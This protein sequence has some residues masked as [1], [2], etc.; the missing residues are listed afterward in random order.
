MKFTADDNP[1]EI[2][3]AS[4]FNGYSVGRRYRGRSKEVDLFSGSSNPGKKISS[5]APVT[6]LNIITIWSVVLFFGLVILA[7]RTA[8]LQLFRGSY[9]SSVAEGNRIRINDLKAQRGIIYDAN[10]VL[11]VEN[12]P[13]K[14]LAIIPVDLPKVD[15]NLHNLATEIS[16]IINKPVNE[17]LDMMKAQSPYSYQPVIIQENLTD[18]QAILVRILS[19]KF[20][21]IT[22]RTNNTRHYLETTQDESLSHILGYE[23][24]INPDILDEYLAKGYLIDDYIGKAG[25]EMSYENLLKGSNGREQVEVDAVGETKELLASDKPQSGKNLVLTIDSELQQVA[26]DSLKKALKSADKKKGTVIVMNPNNGALLAMVSLPAYDNNLFSKGIDQN[27]FSQLINDPNQPLFSRAISG[28]YPSGSTIKMIMGAAALQEGVINESTTFNSVG[29]IRVGQ[30]FF[31]DWKAGGHGLTNIIKA[32]AESVNTFFYIIGGGYNDFTGLGIE[33]MKEYA[34]KFNLNKPLGIDLPNEASGF[35]PD[36]VWK[37]KTKNE[38]W[39]IGDTYHAAIGQGDVLVTPLQVAEYTS[40]FANGGTLYQPHVLGS[41]LDSDN[42]LV[43]SFETKV[44][45]NNFISS[46]NIDIIRRGLRQGVL[47]GSS[48]RLGTLPFTVAS[49]TGTAEFADAKEPH[50]WM[51]AFAPYEKSQIV[52]TVLVEEGV[53]GSTVAVPVAYDILNWWGQNRYQE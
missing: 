31:P 53:E 35:Y 47:A 12:V 45:G 50:A 43:R 2:L 51:T 41:I 23:G 13:S 18:D 24:K 46:K 49:K 25:V 27:T 7:S 32:L 14:S 11:L 8:Y 26:E 3:S 40:F 15:S 33:K 34:E 9:F 38:Q 29:G 42:K 39:Y 36:P 28:Q 5:L 16:N 22:L 37:E 10:R 30:W 6:N 19:G 20:T 52:V 21:G 1:F 44:L 48:K 4:K 17:L